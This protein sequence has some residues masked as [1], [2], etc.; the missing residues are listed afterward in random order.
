MDL[1]S[2]HPFWLSKNGLL[3]VYP[4]LNSNVTCEVVVLGA[5]ITGAL[6]AH[7]LTREGLNVVV[8]DRRD[9][10]Q[11][12]TCASTAL[13]QYEIDTPLS[14]LIEI[15]GRKDAERAYMVCHESIDK[16]EQL[17]RDVRADCGFQRRK[18]V[19][20]ATRARDVKLLQAEWQARRDAGIVVTFWDQKEIEARFS[21]SRPAALVSEQAA[22]VDAYR[23]VH[24]LLAHAAAQ[25]ARIFDRTVIDQQEST[26][27]GV[28][29]VTDRGYVI[30]AQHAVFATG[31]EVGEFLPKSVASLKSTFAFATEPL[32]EFPGWWERCLLWETARPY[33]YL[34][35]TEDG[36]AIVGGEDD[37][38]R[39]PE[40]RDRLLTKK[41]ARLEELFRAMFPKMDMEVACSWAGT[42]AETK[43]GLAY[44]GTVRQMP[45]CYFA[46]GFGGNGITYSLVAAE[47]I[48][49]ALI[50]RNNSDARLFRFDR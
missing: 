24:A 43:D 17:V 30:Q 20:L 18:S 4:S 42:F 46:L 19:Y 23:L 47:I 35:T 33:L 31:Y 27:D 39:N 40:R 5:G 21:F 26:K 8:V 49:D 48:R 7:H 36:R 6:A 45:R 22:E 9:A 34:R 29:L 16:I 2:P 25:G 32:T 12:S 13:L 14:Q 10:G 15:F 37:P 11:G 28:R 41:A 1:T 44:I 38:F 3:G 50:G